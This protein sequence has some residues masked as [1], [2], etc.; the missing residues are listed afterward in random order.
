MTNRFILITACLCLLTAAGCARTQGPEPLTL[1][2]AQKQFVSMLNEE[3]GLD[4]HVRAFPNTFWVYL[5]MDRM[6]FQMKATPQGPVNSGQSTTK[7]A[8]NYLDSSFD[9]GRFILKYDIAPAKAYGKD[10]GYKSEFSEEYK[11]KQRHILTA[12][13]RTF[14]EAGDAPS[15]FV[16]VIADTVNGLQSTTYIHFKDLQRAYMDPSFH[17]EYARRIVS[18]QP[19]GDIRLI[20]DTQGR[21]VAYFDLTWPR[22]LAKQMAH[23]ITFK[24]QQSAFPPSLD[25][26]TELLTIAAAAVS[27]YEYTEFNSVELI[28]MNTQTAYSIPRQELAEFAHR[29]P[30]GRLIH[31]QFQ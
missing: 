28:D 19:A 4:V 3:N 13:Y 7:P 26:K 17:E 5:P 10:Y 25:T 9:G 31:I 6:F 30:E 2:D 23:R 20:G 21:N 8:V 16:L 18:E 14:N 22:F 15:F 29:P 1:T 24:Y 27:G 11:A 12:I